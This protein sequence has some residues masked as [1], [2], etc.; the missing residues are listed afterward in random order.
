VHHPLVRRRRELYRVRRVP[1]IEIRR[2]AV[3]GRLVGEV[4]VPACELCFAGERLSEVVERSELGLVV[5]GE[6]ALERCVC[7]R[8]S[9]TAT[10][11]SSCLEP[12]VPHCVLDAGARLGRVDGT[13]G[14]SA[15]QVEI[16]RRGET[17]VERRGVYD[18]SVRPS[19]GRSVISGMTGHDRDSGIVSIA[20]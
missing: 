19:K 1:P 15:D 9:A 10:A 20:R 5:Q 18:G 12:S 16:P 11:T 13:T 2:L 14:D 17:G 3:L 6:A 4:P 7:L 8:G